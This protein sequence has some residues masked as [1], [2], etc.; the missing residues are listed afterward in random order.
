MLAVI[1]DGCLKACV[2]TEARHSA[3]KPRDVCIGR[4]RCFWITRLLQ[5]SPIKGGALSVTR[6]LSVSCLRFS[7]Y[8]KTIDGLE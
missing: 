2:N 7:A 6:C 1:I 5:C 4:C 8:R 3:V